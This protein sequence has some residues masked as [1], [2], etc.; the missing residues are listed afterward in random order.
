MNTKIEYVGMGTKPDPEKFEILDRLEIGKFTILLVKYDGC[1]T[2][3]GEKLLLYDGIYTS[4]LTLDPH[5]FEN[6][7][8]IARFAP[9]Q[10]GWAL[11]KTCALSLNDESSIEFN[12]NIPEPEHGD[13]IPIEDF[14]DMAR[15]GGFIDYDGHGYLATETLVSNVL[16]FPSEMKIIQPPKWATHIVWYNR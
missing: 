11:A 16:V 2:F 5:F 14:I 15:W 6:H 8:I 12:K 3:N 7:P 9:T 4:S 1:L 10:L 13:H